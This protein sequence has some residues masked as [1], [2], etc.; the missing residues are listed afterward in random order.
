MRKA[1]F[2]GARDANTRMADPLAYQGCG[3]RKTWRQ[4]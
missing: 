2:Q 1:V 4:R 3:L